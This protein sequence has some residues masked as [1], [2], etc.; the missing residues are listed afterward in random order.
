MDAGFDKNKCFSGQAPVSNEEITCNSLKLEG[1]TKSSVQVLK[2]GTYPR[3]S[4][5]DMDSI[6]G[7]EGNMETLITYS[8]VKSL[9]GGVYFAARK[10]D[11]PSLA[12]CTVTYNK[13]LANIG[14]GMD[15]A[16]G[17]F[18]AP[19][20]GSYRFSFGGQGTSS[21][22]GNFLVDLILND[23]TQESFIQKVYTPSQ[24]YNQISYTWQ[25]NIAK[26]DRIHLIQRG[27]WGQLEVQNTIAADPVFIGELISEQ[28]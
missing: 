20:G 8:D 7:Y 28:I 13:V 24:P 3:L 15:G 4:Y 10:T 25:M 23:S 5:C 19:V 11:V 21:T 27:G 6:S 1:Y 22:D 16:S 26:G 17:V 12:N 18:T 9:P 2:T 14:G